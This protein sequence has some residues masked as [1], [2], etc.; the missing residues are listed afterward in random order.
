MLS[1]AL[2]EAVGLSAPDLHKEAFD[3]QQHESPAE[4]VRNSPWVGYSYRAHHKP[5]LRYG[6]L[7]L[8][9]CRCFAGS[10]IG[11]TDHP[12]WAEEAIIWKFHILRTSEL[13]ARLYLKSAEVSR[14]REHDQDILLGVVKIN[15]AFK[16]AEGESD[17]AEWL[18]VQEG[19]GKMRLRT[20]YAKNTSKQLE[21]LEGVYCSGG[22]PSKVAALRSKK[23]QRLYAQN[24]IRTAHIGGFPSN[25]SESLRFQIDTPF[26][27]QLA[28]AYQRDSG[29]HLLAPLVAGEHLF[30]RLQRDRL[31]DTDRSIFY[32]AE[33]FCGVK[34]LHNLDIV[35]GGL[36][37][38]SILISILGHTAI[39]DHNL[40]LQEP[41][42]EVQVETI[43]EVIW[44]P[45]PEALLGQG[46]SKLSE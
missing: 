25:V 13:P 1:V 21:D 19:A 9:Q 36:R 15:L 12:D 10:N 27:A 7:C 35:Y 42:T 37:P 39:F 17:A 26:I 46:Y 24:T 20:R 40:F 16:K 30:Y 38:K 22:Q 23:R 43:D 32:A 5:Y 29:L 14:H 4:H 28:F 31:F 45:S 2:N 11:T 34:H 33:L 3:I 41:G 44:Y 18:D 6:V 8:D